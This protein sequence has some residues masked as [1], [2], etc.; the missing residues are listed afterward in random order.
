MS[1][2]L[3]IW[4]SQG[5]ISNSYESIATVTVGAGGSSSI[6]FSSISGTYKHL[7]IRGIA[8]YSSAYNS[9]GRIQFNS[10]TSANYAQHQLYGDGSAASSYGYSGESSGIMSLLSDAQFGNFV[11]DVLD[12]TDSNKYKTVRTLGGVDKNGSGYA[13]MGSS[14]WRSTAAITSITIFAPA[15]GGNWA[16]YSSFAL[17]GIK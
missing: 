11:T 10:D 4:A 16:Q 13:S 1:P 6:T 5:R 7:Q 8:K 9:Y 17:Y 14:L 2:I 12:Y 15:S 3:G